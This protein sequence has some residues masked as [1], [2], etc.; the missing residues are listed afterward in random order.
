[1]IAIYFHLRS[2]RFQP[3]C[4]LIHHIIQRQLGFPLQ[5]AFPDYSNPPSSLPESV[6]LASI[7][8]NIPGDLFPP[9]LGPRFW[10]A[11]EVAV[12][13]VP[14]ATVHEDRCI[15]FGEHQIRAAGKVSP[16]KAE[17]KP[18]TVQPRSKQ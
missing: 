9:E 7:P 11:K 5:R 1:L 3:C 10:E 14:K 18:P 2:A 6:H 8:S 4:T 17:A 15:S 16:M 12:M 13:S